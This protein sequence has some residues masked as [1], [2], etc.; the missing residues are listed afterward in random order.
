MIYGE[1][2]NVACKETY[3]VIKGVN[4]LYEN[5]KR[6]IVHANMNLW[7]CCVNKTVLHA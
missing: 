7:K 4:R 6:L 3:G 1:R 5:K 2:G